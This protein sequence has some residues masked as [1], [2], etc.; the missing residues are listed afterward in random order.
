MVACP[1]CDFSVPA[2]DPW[3]EVRH[4]MTTHSDVIQRRLLDAGLA[5]MSVGFCATPGARPPAPKSYRGPGRYRHYKGPEYEVL[6]L[7]LHESEL[8]RLV[9][10]RPLTG[11]SKLDGSPLDWWARP[12]DNFN[13]YV[14]YDGERRPRFERIG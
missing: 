8:Y 5:D 1:Y 9:I 10:Y 2:D 7:A 6:G 3:A 11:G 14:E 13:A 4:M 12:V